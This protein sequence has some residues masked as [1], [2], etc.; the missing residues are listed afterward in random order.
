MARTAS[1][2]SCAATISEMLRSDEPC[3]MAITLT[4]DSP[5]AAKTLPAI[6]GVP[7]IRSPTTAT[8]AIE[9]YA[10]T[11]SMWL[12][13][14]SNSSVER[15]DFTTRETSDEL[16]TKQMLF[17]DEACEIIRTLARYEATAAR[18]FAAMPGMPCM[19]MPLTV[20]RLTWRI[21]VTALTPRADGWPSTLM[22]V[23]GFSWLKLLR[24]RIGIHCL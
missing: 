6:P 9:S 14:K 17:S 13:I 10:D 3:E 19:P 11:S 16:I 15:S 8:T 23:P 18:A 24:M 1:A 12:S 4:P 2:A 20:I 7:C 22:R 5:S 21:E